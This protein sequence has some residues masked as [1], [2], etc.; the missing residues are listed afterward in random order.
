MTKPNA[1][2]TLY[3]DHN[4]NKIEIHSGSYGIGATVAMISGDN[5][6][7][8][9]IDQWLYAVQG[10]PISD[11]GRLLTMIADAREPDFDEVERIAKRNGFAFNNEGALV[12]SQS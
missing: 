4:G 12:S 1:T 5:R 2:F 9:T 11:I 8:M 7:E 10:D 3:T 6:G